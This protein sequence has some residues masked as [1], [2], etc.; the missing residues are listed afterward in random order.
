MYKKITLT[1]L[2]FVLFFGVKFANAQVIINE[3]Q[4]NPTTERFIE[5]YNNS[6]SEVDLTD[7]YIQRKTATGTDFG[8]LI[9]KTYF[10]GKTI[11][12]NAYYLISK[13]S[14]GLSSFTL[15]DSNTIQLKNSNQ[16]VVDKIGWGSGENSVSGNPPEGKS[17]QKT[18]NGWI[19]G[20][21]TPG[22]INTDIV[23]ETPDDNSSIDNTET[24]ASTSSDSNISTS[25]AKIIVTPTIKAK[26][27]TKTIAFANLP[28]EIETNILGYSNEKIIGG[29]YFWNFGDGDSKITLDTNKIMHVYFYP[30]EYTISL[31]YYLNKGSNLPDAIDRFAIKIIP[32]D[33]FISKVGDTND[34]FVELT[35][36][37]SS[38]IDLSNWILLSGTKYFILPKNTFI[39]PKKQMRVSSKLTGFILNDKE[40]L[41]LVTPLNE[42]AYN[43]GAS[44]VEPILSNSKIALV[45][46]VN[47]NLAAKDPIIKKEPIALVQNQIIPGLGLEANPLKADDSFLKKNEN[48]YFPYVFFS[49]FLILAGG[50]V[51]F[52]RRKKFVSIPKNNDDF[53]ILDE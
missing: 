3:V 50:S 10:V 8:S 26:I 16:E 53:E 36:N 31:E 38:E 41:K 9:S 47:K 25:K 52:I 40:K 1:V 11:G 2:F 44:F 32:M 4:I 43:Y 18:S 49:V 20:S 6:S 37:S 7:W 14:L 23:S 48:S 35:N 19:I 13:D 29:K 17:I 27:S 15:T 5:L 46:T 30:G 33:V 39:M 42:I 51:Y 34:F 45:E 22:A 21:P 24:S 28:V 12:A